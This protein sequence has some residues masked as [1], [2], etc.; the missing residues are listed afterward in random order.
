MCNYVIEIIIFFN[1]RA[2]QLQ[3]LLKVT[4]MF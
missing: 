2:L 4:K 3:K 1:Y